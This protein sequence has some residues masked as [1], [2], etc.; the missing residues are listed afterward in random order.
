ME[1]IQ[2]GLGLPYSLPPNMSVRF[3]IASSIAQACQ[4]V[5]YTGDVGFQTFLYW[6]ETDVRKIF[7]FLIEK[8]PKEAEKTIVE[9]AGKH[10]SFSMSV[11][12]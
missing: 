2:P 4:D 7:M 12:N 9:P 10:A 3:R 5:G 6:G 1:V 11:S 8:L